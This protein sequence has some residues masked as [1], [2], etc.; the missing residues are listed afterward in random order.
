M[1]KTAAL[2]LALCMIFALAGCGSSS[3][4]DEVVSKFCGA[5]KNFDL[6]TMR[7]CVNGTDSDPLDFDEEETPAEVLKIL[8]SNAGK[9]TY[10]IGE[11]KVSGE[12]GTVDV[13]FTYPDV[14]VAVTTAMGEYFMQALSMA[15]SGADEEDMEKLLEDTLI[16]KL[17]ETPATEA[18]ASIQ[19]N[20]IQTDDGWKIKS[21]D[22][23]V[24]NIMMGNMIKAFEGIEDDMNSSADLP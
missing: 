3:K 7:S 14:T 16:E 22:A 4:P 18:T 24:L 13:D 19:F 23:D 17:K 10:A 21:L 9:I 6:E 20:C 12:T 5:L 2:L 8:K 11:T 15:F 1:K